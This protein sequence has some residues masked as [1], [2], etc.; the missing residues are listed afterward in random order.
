MRY[1]VSAS[2]RTDIPAFYASWFYNRLKAGFCRTVNP[3][4]RS[5]IRNVSLLPDDVAAF[6]FWTRYS[7]PFRDGLVALDD[8]GFGYYFLHTLN[9]YGKE[10]ECH[11]P[12]VKVLITE[13]LELS[14]RIGAERLIWRYDPVI[15]TTELD[16]RFH[17]GNFMRLAAALQGGT[18]RVVISFFKE[19]RKTRMNLKGIDYLPATEQE[20]FLL[21]AELAAIADEY[22]MQLQ[23]CGLKGAAGQVYGGKCID[24]RMIGDLYGI[25]LSGR[26]DH[27]QPPGCRCIRS[28]DIG[29]YDTCLHGCRYCYATGNIHRARTRY[30]CHE[31]DAEM[32]A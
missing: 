18:T 24:E 5:Q 7:R 32:L 28:V 2:R 20:Q 12:S 3:F 21:A 29:C 10:I 14:Q 17:A 19:Y 16:M 15:L 13:F 9:G 25:E 1:V 30:A 6:V 8:M 31:I 23:C 4:N 11:L 26:K 22:G 27:G